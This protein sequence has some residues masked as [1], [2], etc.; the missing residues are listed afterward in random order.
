MANRSKT[1]Y[2]GV[3]NDLQRRVYEHKGKLVPGFTA[4]Y[5]ITMLV[6]FEETGFVEEAIQREKMIK[7]WVRRKKLALIES[8]N[9][10]WQDLSDGWFDKEDPSLRSG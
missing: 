5:N 8:L 6:Y 3:T 10:E 7:G 4:K 2:T 1:L 9:P